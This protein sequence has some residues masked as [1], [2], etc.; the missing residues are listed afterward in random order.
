[1]KQNLFEI[2]EATNVELIQQLMEELGI[3]AKLKGGKFL[4]DIAVYIDNV[5]LYRRPTLEEIRIELAKYR[6]TTIENIQRQTLYACKYA[7]KKEEINV[8][9]FITTMFNRLKLGINSRVV[10]KT[11]FKF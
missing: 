5:K 10:H 8:T 11:D 9:D 2:Q 7:N 6:N 4:F 3:N 1:M